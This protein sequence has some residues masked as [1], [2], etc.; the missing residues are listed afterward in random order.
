MTV[1]KKFLLGAL[2]VALYLLGAYAIKQ[3]ALSCAKQPIIAQPTQ[4][5]QRETRKVTIAAAPIEDIHAE[6]R[7]QELI[8]AS[9]HKPLVVKIFATWCGPCQQCGTQ[10]SGCCIRITR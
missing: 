3:G 2:L 7:L 6:K 1:Q 10:L 8:T 5:A 9:T 4:E